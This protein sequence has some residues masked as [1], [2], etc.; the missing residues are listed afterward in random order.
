MLIGA[1]V[2][3]GAT[4]AATGARGG[5]LVARPG[6]DGLLRFG[7]P[8]E[9]AVDFK[10]FVTAPVKIAAVDVVALG[11]PTQ[12]VRVRS[13]DGAVGVVKAN[14]R[15]EEVV[16]L[17]DLAVVPRLVG[18]DARDIEALVDR[19][20]TLEYK[21]LGLALWTAI[22]HIELAIWDMLGKVAGRRC[23]DFMGPE[24]RSSIPFYLSSLNRNTTPDEEVAWLA[25]VVG[26]TG[27]T[28]I[29]I[30]AGGR[31]S[32]NA[33]A[34]PGRQ[35]AL[36]PLARK[37]FG[38]AFTI[39]VD[40]NGSFD[41][42]AAIR[43]VDMLEDYGVAILEEPCPFQDHRMTR[44]VT[45]YVNRTGKRIRIA[46]G[47]QDGALEVWRDYLADGTLH[48]LQPD[49][50]YNG[51]M[52]RTLRVARMAEATG[53][54]VAPHYPRNGVET[55]ELLHFAC[56]IPNLHGLQEYRGRPRTLDFNHSPRLELKG[57]RLSLPPGAGFGADYDPDIFVRG[58]RLNAPAN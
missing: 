39:Y 22:G 13:T 47:E 29:K 57:G 6:A 54:G 50:M 26:R 5:N 1:A 17:L 43:L 53:V 38:D 28:G 45:S 12:F 36:V 18:E 9:P 19:I 40:A 49:F 51:G 10:R 30:K 14:S 52:A 2:L 35:E 25:E 34:S 37:T 24:R 31:M 33:D 48:V 46:G 27:A 42:P 3:A 44:Q 20:A 15:M 21:F 56:H 58:R 32:R 41:A 8:V 55:V 11:G 16:S 4:G 7:L 23:I